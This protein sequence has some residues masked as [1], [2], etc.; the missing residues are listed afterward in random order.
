[1]CS[2]VL[3]WSAAFSKSLRSIADGKIHGFTKNA[4]M[5]SIVVDLMR[6]TAS[7]PSAGACLT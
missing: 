6:A 5:C 1:M 2:T 3:V 7:V 4:K